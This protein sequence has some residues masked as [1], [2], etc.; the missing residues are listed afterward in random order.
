VYTLLTNLLFVK[1]NLIFVSD[2][3]VALIVSMADSGGC[4]TAGARIA[5]SSEDAD[6]YKSPPSLAMPLTETSL[7]QLEFVGC[8][9]NKIPIELIL[10]GG[11]LL[12]SMML[13]VSSYALNP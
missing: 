8:V 12:D 2:V 3:Y 11:L 6:T 9:A 1:E 4:G 7:T 5:G 13:P 10:G